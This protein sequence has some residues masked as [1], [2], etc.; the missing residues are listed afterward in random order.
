MISEGNENEMNCVRKSVEPSQSNML[1]R[2]VKMFE[3]LENAE[4]EISYRW[5]NC[6]SCK[7]CKKHSRADIMS[8]KEEVEQYVINK[9]VK[10]GPDRR[11]TTA[12][13]PMMFNPLHKLAPNKDKALHIY[14]QQVKKV[15]QNLQDKEN[16]IQSEAKLKSLGHVEF[17][18]N[19]TPE[20]K[21]MLAENPVQNFIPWRAVWNRNSIG[22]PCRLVFDA[23][24]PTA[25]GTSLNDILAKG[26]N[27]INKLVEIVIRWS[28]HKFGFHTDVK[29]MYNTVQLREEHWCFQRYI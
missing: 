3:E 5:N 27:N 7:A 2:N 24:Q 17:V 21:E 16:G 9:C 1:V 10:V 23:S 11:I 22:T 19:L 15:N 8:V 28:T 14:N 6:R 26:K 29:K 4:S 12:L 25:S 20:Q 18:K 13:L